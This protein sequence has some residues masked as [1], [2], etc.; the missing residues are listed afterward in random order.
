MGEAIKL[1]RNQG[2]SIQSTSWSGY[3]NQEHRMKHWVL[4]FSMANSRGSDLRTSVRF[5]SPRK[6]KGHG[7]G[8]ARRPREYSRRRK[9][10]KMPKGCGKR[11]LKIRRTCPC[12]WRVWKLA[13]E[14]QEPTG[15]LQCLLVWKLFKHQLQAFRLL[16]GLR[17]TFQPIQLLSVFEPSSPPR[18]ELTPRRSRAFHPGASP[19]GSLWMIAHVG[20]LATWS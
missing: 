3:R 8:T 13:Q 18:F 6:I 10:R 16:R 2:Y 5:R 14:R 7:K 11:Q 9:T 19:Q 20:K 1:R 12:K 4:F 15:V 17:H